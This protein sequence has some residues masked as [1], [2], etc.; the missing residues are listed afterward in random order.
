MLYQ[1]ESMQIKRVF[2]MG[3]KG[4]QAAVIKEIQDEVDLQN[5]VEVI[6][7]AFL[8]VAGDFNLTEKNAPTNP[9]FITLSKLQEL[10]AKNTRFFGLFERGSQLGFIAIEKGPDL[11]YFL[12]KLAVIP[13]VRHRG[14]GAQ[15]LNFAFEYVKKQGGRTISIG[16]INEHAILKKWYTRHGFQE[17]GTKIFPHLPFSVCFMEKST[18]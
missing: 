3:Q 10:K 5:S 16:I 18:I 7:K 2:A 4:I 6:R 8:T 11:T 15:L 14:F 9:A 17:T 1:K 13:P 12:E